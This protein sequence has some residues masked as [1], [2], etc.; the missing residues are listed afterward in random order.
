MVRWA[1]LR[2][3][4]PDSSWHYD[5]L[6]DRVSWWHRPGGAD[7]CAGAP[8][9][10]PDACDLFAFRVPVRPDIATIDRFD[11]VRLPDHRRLYLDYEGPLTNNR[12]S[13][14]RV[15]SG[16]CTWSQ[17]MPGRL[18][19]HIEPG[20]SPAPT[21]AIHWHGRALGPQ[22]PLTAETSWIFTLQTPPG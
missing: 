5:W 13:V 2:H 22:E 16:L 9:L 18:D 8:D 6:I 19:V 4:L 1:L 15:A 21:Q 20:S 7:R 11:A 10:D 3:D 14:R 17:P 12:G